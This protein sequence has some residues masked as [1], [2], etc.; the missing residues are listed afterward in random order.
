VGQNYEQ[1]LHPWRKW[2]LK[3]VNLPKLDEGAD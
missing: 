2:L 1:A 3:I